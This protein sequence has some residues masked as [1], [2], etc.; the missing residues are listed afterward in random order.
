MIYGKFHTTPFTLEVL[1]FSHATGLA[2]EMGMTEKSLRWIAMA[3]MNALTFNAVPPAGQSFIQRHVSVMRSDFISCGPTTRLTLVVLSEMSPWRAV[4]WVAMV[5]AHRY[6]QLCHPRISFNCIHDP[7]T[8][9]S[10]ARLKLKWVNAP[11]NDHTCTTNYL[12]TSLC[13]VFSAN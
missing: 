9:P 11:I 10:I 13:F 8:L 4:G 12:H 6:T 1:H 7:F 5:R 2:L 3:F